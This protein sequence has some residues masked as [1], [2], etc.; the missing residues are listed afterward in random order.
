MILI[1]TVFES[2]YKA[3]EVVG[4]AGHRQYVVWIREVGYEGE[5]TLSK[6]NRTCK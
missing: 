5:S 6:Q 4:R 1:V 3:R 2:F